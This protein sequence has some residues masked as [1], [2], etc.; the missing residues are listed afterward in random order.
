MRGGR[1]GARER[2]AVLAVL[3]V[4]V[5][6]Q[7]EMTARTWTR[8]F[9]DG[10]L[11]YDFDNADFTRRARDGIL[12]GQARTQLGV[13]SLPYAAWEVPAGE[14][15]FYT[16]H[17]FLL[18]ALFQLL[19]RVA[20]DGEWVSRVYAL[21][22]AAAAV[23][24]TV[25]ALRLGS[26][27]LVAAGLGALVLVNVP[28]FATYQS[29][30]KY[31]LDGMAL[32]SWFFVAVAFALVRPSPAKT[33]AVGG[34][35]YFAA[36]AHWTAVLLVG[37]VVA[38]LAWE[39]VARGRDEATAPVIAA[40]VGAAAGL[41]TVLLT[42][43]WLAGGWS[44]LA[45]DLGAAARMRTD[46]SALPSGAWAQ[47]QGLYVRMN[48]GPVVPWLAASVACGLAF[49]AWRHRLQP[50]TGIAGRLLPAFIATTLAAATAWQLGF[51]QGSFVHVFW[52]L[53]FVLP[54][55]GLT[56]ALYVAA[57]GIAWRAGASVA[58]LA[59][60][61]HLH[62]ASREAHEEL[63][64]L[65]RGT[66]ADISFLVSQRYDPFT[67]FVFVPMHD[68]PLNAWFT[69]PIFPYYTD[70]EV[71]VLSGAGRVGPGDRLL[72]LRH[73]DQQ[74]I[75]PRLERFLGVTLGEERCGLRFC[76]YD[77]RP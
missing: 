31:E 36:L 7:V 66:P 43:T 32:G 55:A 50:E 72:L 60:A 29:C 63:L 33:L 12:A 73:E 25:V 56:A 57:P 71:V 30:I 6:L 38:W 61:A 74:E 62:L 26:G 2:V 14:P 35:A 39:R 24:G 76:A 69:G 75:L 5:G 15:N 18:K 68:V 19:V 23:G 49:L 28:V 46:V 48:F 11:H 37:A 70:R 40:V 4:L 64:R 59:V 34:L 20:G 22:V 1:A 65:Q 21:A 77:V 16:H 10:A 47:R 53:W 54:L 52:Q 58:I 8:P 42:F 9:L 44:A 45:A 27:S 17:P 13:S 67:R 41:L 51:P 3:A